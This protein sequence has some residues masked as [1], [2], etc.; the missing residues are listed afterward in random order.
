MFNVKASHVIFFVSVCAISAVLAVSGRTPGAK[1]DTIHYLEQENGV[2]KSVGAAESIKASTSGRKPLTEAD[3]FA[4]LQQGTFGPKESEIA[5][6]VGGTVE[7]WLS[8][9]FAAPVSNYSG[10]DRDQ[11]AQW[12][13]VWGYDYCRSFA[14]GTA[15]RASCP[16]QFTSINPIRRDFFKNAINGPDQLR[17][18]VAFALSQILVV[19]EADLPGA[20]T[21][22]FA[23]YQQ[24]LTNKAFGTYGDLLRSVTLHPLMGRYLTL[25]HS[26]KAGPNENYGR[27]LLQLFSVGLCELNLNGT[28]KSGACIPTYDNQVVR[29]YAFALSGYTYPAGGFYSGNLYGLNAQYSK[30]EMVPVA[31]LR[32]TASR[33]LLSGVQVPSGSTAP[34]AL[35]AVIRSIETHPNLA[36]F[37]SKQLIQ[38]LVTSNPSDNYVQRVA[39]AFNAGKFGDYGSGAVGDLKATVAAILLDDEAR[40]TA[41]A[42]RSGKLREPTLL[43]TSLVRALEGYTDGEEMGTSWQSTGSILGQPFLSS[44]SVFNFYTPDYKIP[45]AN[46]VLAPQFQLVT[47]N[48]SLGWFNAIDDLVYGWYNGGVGLAPKQNAPGAVGTK[49]G[50]GQFELD[51]QK[52]DQLVKRLDKILTGSRLLPAQRGLIQQQIEQITQAS[53]VPQGSTW[54]IERVKLATF[55]VASSPTYLTQQ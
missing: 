7:G 16:D 48:S 4:L 55:L 25:L 18:R 29:E 36:P 44:P 14:D 45:G 13:S 38:F 30:G 53:P 9:Q 20:G 5:R 11:I 46:G 22:A 10:R 28:L 2:I 37:I 8:E 23:D 6:L 12:S 32:D 50:F 54:T 1:F 26:D 34:Q 42:N 51:A 19:S 27:E 3:A 17:Q 24:L 39:T 31:R 41:S 49:L 15:Q 40:N 33:Q 47:P 52:P 21:Y 35:S 43:V